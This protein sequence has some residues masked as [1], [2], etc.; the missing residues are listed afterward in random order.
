[1]LLRNANG[2][3]RDKVGQAVLWARSKLTIG[4][5]H[6]YSELASLRSTQGFRRGS[7][8]NHKNLIDASNTKTKS[9][10]S[11][12]TQQHSLSCSSASCPTRQT[13][14]FPSR[15]ETNKLQARSTNHPPPAQKAA[16]HY[17]LFELENQKTLR[18]LIGQRCWLDS[19]LS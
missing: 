7:W 16:S 12:K 3:K 5:I 11:T 10:F 9:Q 17:A 18:N 8:F 19:V 4:G 14:T 6:V 2:Y 1:M 15:F 13:S